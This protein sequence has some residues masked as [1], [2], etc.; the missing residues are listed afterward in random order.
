MDP[1]ALFK[2]SSSPILFLLS[3]CFLVEHSCLE[4]YHSLHHS[5][6]NNQNIV[7]GLS[8]GLESLIRFNDNIV[9][10]IHRLTGKFAL[11][12]VGIR[13]YHQF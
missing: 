3:Y 4:F 10:I 6:S 11:I 13:F 12:R 1:E 8:V 7:A 5:I 9:K 2:N